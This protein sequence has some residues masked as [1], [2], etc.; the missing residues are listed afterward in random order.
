[1]APSSWNYHE[2]ESQSETYWT[3][4]R[5]S[6]DGAALATRGTQLDF[7]QMVICEVGSCW[8]SWLRKRHLPPHCLSHW[9]TPQHVYFSKE[10]NPWL[11]VLH[12]PHG[13]Q[14]KS[15]LVT[16]LIPLSGQCPIPVL[17]PTPVASAEAT[18]LGLLVVLVCWILEVGARNMLWTCTAITIQQTFLSMS[19]MLCSTDTHPRFASSSRHASSYHTTKY[20]ASQR[21]IPSMECQWNQKIT[22]P[23]HPNSS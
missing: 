4:C 13:A 9:P 23:T 16:L 5:N 10:R 2:S 21:P 22:R 18:S 3:S 7:G 8:R 19:P 6:R 20:N 15:P 14:H 12:L 17:L 11:P 1:M